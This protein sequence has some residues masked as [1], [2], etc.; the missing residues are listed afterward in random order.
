[1]VCRDQVPVEVPVLL[2]VTLCLVPGIFLISSITFFKLSFISLTV[3]SEP[4][5]D[6]GTGAAG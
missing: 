4:K 1:M 5:G 3:D 2:V 6:P